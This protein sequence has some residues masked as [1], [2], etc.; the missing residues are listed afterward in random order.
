M[1]FSSIATAEPNRP[2]VLFITIDHLND[3]VAILGGHPDVRTPN[4]DR[5]AALSVNFTNVH[6]ASPVC[7]R[8]VRKSPCS[9][10]LVG[11]ETVE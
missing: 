1:S 10:N 7:N 11:I 5:L 3:Y 2:D 9:S 8:S 4:L 6:A